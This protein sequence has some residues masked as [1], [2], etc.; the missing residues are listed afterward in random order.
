M[1]DDYLDF[2]ILNRIKNVLKGVLQA[3]EANNKKCKSLQSVTF[4]MT[5]DMCSVMITADM[6][7]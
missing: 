4:D 7:L 2:Y 5:F 6:Q 1:L 3:H